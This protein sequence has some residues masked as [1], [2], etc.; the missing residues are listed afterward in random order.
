MLHLA[1]VQKQGSSGEPK[2][3]LIARQESAYTWALM[4]ETEAIAIAQADLDSGTESCLV[5]IELSPSREILSIQAATDWVIDLVKNYL[6]VGIT[7]AF[8][9]KERERIEQGLQSVT[10]ERQDL[11]RRTIELEA[12]RDEIQELEVKLQKQIQA[13]EAENEQLKQ[14]IEALKGK[15]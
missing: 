1:Q 15:G 9:E 8:L 11:A 4:D 7:P 10:V 14:E 3:R 6:A 13:L 12:R 5:L 2:L